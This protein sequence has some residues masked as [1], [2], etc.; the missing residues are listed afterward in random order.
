[1]PIAPP[2][3]SH[4][5]LR[6]AALLGA[7]ALALGFGFGFGLL[8]PTCAAAST[9]RGT[10]TA[11]NT[12]RGR[13]TAANTSRG[14]RAAHGS[15]ARAR[16]AHGR[17]RA[18]AAHGRASRACA[19][20]RSVKR[21]RQRAA[22]PTR[23]SSHHPA[24]A[25][26]PSYGPT[27]VSLGTPSPGG[28][29]TTPAEGHQPGESGNL[30]GES[31]GVVTDPI[32]SRFLTEMPF[33]TSSFWIQPW[34]AYLDTWPASRLLDSLGI[35]FNVGPSKAEATAQLLQESGFTLA[36]REIGW[37]SISYQEPTKILG[38]SDIRMVLDAMH[39]HGLRPLILLNANSGDPGPSKHLTLETSSSAPAGAQSVTLTAASAAAVVPGKTGFDGLTFGGEPDLLI[40]SI[41][42]GDVAT[43]SEPLPSTLAAGA[44]PGTTLLYAPFTR[45]TLPDG[46]PNPQFQATLAG[47][48]SYVG[49]V[50]K[51]AASVFGPEGYDVEIWNELGF[52]SQF[53]NS[54]HYYSPSGEWAAERGG[55]DA[56]GKT[57]AEGSAE[58]GGG[59]EAAGKTEAG[60]SAE[61]GSGTEAAGKTEAGGSA[62]TGSGTEAGG[63]AGAGG[64]TETQ[65]DSESEYGAEA[66]EGPEELTKGQ[67]TLAVIKALLHETVAY[68]RNPANGI[69]P[70][71]GITDGFASQSPFPSGAGTPVGLTALSKH[72]YAGLQSYPSAYAFKNIVPLNAFGERDIEKGSE[73][74]FFVPTYQS[75]FPEVTLTGTHTETLIR[76]LAPFTTDIYGFPHGREVGPAGGSPPQEWVTEY[77]LGLGKA[78][79]M[80]P[81]GTT[82]A[83]GSSATLTAA[84]KEHFH[85][86]VALRS[87]VADVSKGI[88]REYFYAAKAGGLSLV[89]EGFFSALEANPNA[90]PGSALGGETMTGLHNMLAQFQG[91]GPGGAPR[92]LQLTR[93]AQDGSHSQF[94]GDGSAA[95]PSLYDRDVLAV[96]PFQSSPTRFVVPVYVMTRDLLTLYEPGQPTSDVQRFD[97]PNETFLITLGNLPETA[98][99]PVISAY[100]PLRD[101]ST[102]ARLVSRVGSSATIE[103]AATDYPRIL[104]I[105]YP[106]A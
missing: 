104:T 87:L 64:G 69:G 34:R 15:T 84:D 63:S 81:D 101:E 28:T 10:Q 49:T 19:T 57:E 39:N 67:V 5:P 11:A 13:Q 52:G 72:P 90:Y 35:N 12:S 3:R 24:N 20:T 59:T 50:C 102:P 77:N 79:V 9:S 45:P 6:S 36:R 56:G 86:K 99:P 4:R 65:N 16:C 68:V 29:S 75:L 103:I 66:G 55:S 100:D 82:P 58:P 18:S 91:P 32:D 76:D 40:T 38:E 33:G 97:L 14:T 53:L 51:L 7:V 73:T 61:T 94:A 42:V 46:R 60:G 31:E 21:E 62:E 41:G 26:G 54:A 83:T 70:G 48:L 17:A 2:T 106:S 80:E 1:M 105:E 30:L 96:L 95:H 44:H 37:G 78:A 74:P 47:W 92:Q 93:I 22:K 43:L 8:I 89:G 27:E 71:V 25:G 98:S 85:A 23:R 88:A